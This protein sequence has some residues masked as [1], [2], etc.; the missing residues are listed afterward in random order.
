MGLD[1]CLQPWGAVP[2]DAGTFRC[3]GLQLAD[4]PMARARAALHQ[5]QFRMKVCSYEFPITCWLV[6]LKAVA[7]MEL[8]MGFKNW[9]LGP[10]G[11]QSQACIFRCQLQAQ[12]CKFR[13][14]SGD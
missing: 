2:C 4:F 3:D 8:C 12:D 1:N 11:M 9:H 13:G 10:G 5:G 7:G 6:G 14:Q